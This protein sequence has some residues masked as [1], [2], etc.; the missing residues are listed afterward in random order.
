MKRPSLEQVADYFKVKQIN[1]PEVAEHFYDYYQSI[2]WKVGKNK[3][4]KD[5]KA[6]VRNWIRQS[7]RYGNNTTK[8]NWT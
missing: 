8:V 5:W 6:A 2:G 1:D 7:K 3:V 4:M